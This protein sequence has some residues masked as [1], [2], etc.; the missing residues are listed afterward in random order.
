MPKKTTA[1]YKV[2]SFC[3][4]ITGFTATVAQIILLRE[5]AVVY[6]S[7]EF[8]YGL[9]IS[10]WL[11][12]V[13]L[14]SQ[15]IKL[16][17]KKPAV[18]MLINAQ[19]LTIPFLYVIIFLT[20][21]IRS[22]FGIIPG[23]IIS[24]SYALIFS[25]LTILPLCLLL[26]LQFSLLS[27]MI[28]EN[29]Y[30][31]EINEVYFKEGLGAITG[32]TLLNFILIFFLKPIHILLLLTI[33][34]CTSLFLLAKYFLQKNNL[35]N[36]LITALMFIVICIYP[37][38]SAL[39]KISLQNLWPNFKIVKT[40][41]SPYGRLTFARIRNDR[42]AFSNSS[43]LFSTTNKPLHEEM[44]DIPLL[45]APQ[46]PQS[47]LMIGGGTGGAL[48]ELLKY[49]SVKKIDYL[50]IDPVLLKNS[51]TFFSSLRSFNNNKVDFIIQDARQYLNSSSKKYDLILSQFTSP[52]TL[53]QNRYFS[54]E[55]FDL[56][57]NHLTNKG[58]LAIA[59]PYSE[60]YMSREMVK[61]DQLIY[62]SFNNSFKNTVIWPASHLYLIG[63]KKE[64][65]NNSSN[66]R[67]KMLQN[68]IKNIYLTP[69][70]LGS[71]LPQL[72]I[73]KTKKL[74]ASEELSLNHDL[75]PNAYFYQQ[76]LWATSLNSPLKYFFSKINMRILVTV[77][78]I[79]FTALIIVKC[80]SRKKVLLIPLA[81]FTAGA[82]SMILQI[83][84]MFLFQVIAGSL[85]YQIGILILLFM[86][87]LCYGSYQNRTVLADKKTKSLNISGT[88]SL[89]FLPAF[90]LFTIAAFSLTMFDHWF[91]MILF[92]F[93]SFLTG[94]PVGRIFGLGLYYQKKHTE[95]PGPL[96]ALI[97]SFD[98]WGGA[99]T[100]FLTTILLLPILGFT[101]TITTASGF[102][103]TSVLLAK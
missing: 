98:I 58:V 29:N 64:L 10:F 56:C 49:R 39:N 91:Y 19:L 85:Y 69:Q 86:C 50:E 8:F 100:A 99:L 38:S 41:E 71:L 62:R 27:R 60:S 2:L 48:D 18:N 51:R 59:L 9:T 46:N 7:Q 79:A 93:I 24:P 44:I 42:V 30:P 21:H 28:S 87:G 45:S 35:K 17:R 94:Y 25:F 36:L 90:M 12:Y 67:T 61:L 47:I 102:V 78:L 37:L 40:A 23:S 4:F 73:Q 55:Y 95:Q 16:F 77:L 83:S 96:A 68:N 72:K 84:N 33:L 103:L 89:L 70:T 14:G 76:I 43:L 13:G 22:I 1:K 54:V 80:R 81:I 63:S 53:M 34:L 5:T 57:K 65:S 6:G 11:F 92:P 97:Y 52:A 74:L 82:G 20:R 3:A 101:G 66:L 15:L 32:G 26:G 75:K 31:L 88:C